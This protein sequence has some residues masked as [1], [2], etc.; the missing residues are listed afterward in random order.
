V[1]IG[2]MG[3]QRQRLGHGVIAMLD[4]GNNIPGFPFNADTGINPPN[5]AP[6]VLN[7]ADVPQQFNWGTKTTLGYNVGDHTFE[8]TGYYLGLSTAAKSASLPGQLDLPF[9]A[10]NPP[11][12]FTGDNF[13]W[14][15]ADF[16][17]AV[18]QTR[19]AN[20]EFNYRRRVSANVE[21]LA[22]IRYMDVQERFNILT[23]DDGIILPPP[24]DPFLQAIYSINTHNRIV[25]PQL[26]FVLEAPLAAWLTLSFE[27][28][29]A[30]GA[31]FFSQDHLLLR[32]DGFEGPSSHINRTLFSHV[33]D[34]GAYANVNF[35]E[36][37]RVRAGYQALWVVD[38]PVA[39]HQVDFDP[40]NAQGRRDYRGSIFFHGPS[41][42]IQFAF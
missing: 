31:N 7:F 40:N 28:K 29:G 38:I 27:S 21:L 10:F 2:S 42:E 39:S 8:L 14:L 17:E 1:G 22:G 34:L 23:D 24:P 11:L 36:H 41:V 9:S 20:V 15:Q 6:T 30:W 4:P 19:I 5:T 12:G 13:L 18:Q 16:V 33:Y 26:G 35:G 37:V 32:G 25:A 3:L